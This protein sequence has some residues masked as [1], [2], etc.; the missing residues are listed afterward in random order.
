MVDEDT[1]IVTRGVRVRLIGIDAP[2]SNE[3]YHTEGKV[4]LEDMI[5]HKEVLLEGCTTDKDTYGRSPRY[6]WLNDELVNAE[7]VK[8]GWAIAMQYELNTKYSSLIAEAEK[9]AIE[10]QAG[11]W[12]TTHISTPIPKTPTP[13]SKNLHLYIHQHLYLYLHRH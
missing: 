13:T 2:E 3:E 5:L 9:E 7:M 10:I 12:A 6:V 11:I 1:V 8:A 4:F